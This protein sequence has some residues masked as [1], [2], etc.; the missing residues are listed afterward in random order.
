MVGYATGLR[1]LDISGLTEPA[2]ARAPGGFLRKAYPV[3]T[4]LQRSPRFFV[5]VNGFPID[6]GIMR[7]PDFTRRYRLVLERNHRFNWTPPGSYILHLFERL[8]GGA[9]S[10]EGPA[11]SGT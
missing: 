3:T 9:A 10:A 2:I 11:S 6:E 7:H 4:L 8:D 5:L 1:V